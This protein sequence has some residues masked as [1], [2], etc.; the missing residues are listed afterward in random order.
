[1]PKACDDGFHAEA[2]AGGRLGLVLH[3]RTDPTPVA[4]KLISWARSHGNQVIADARDAAR[5]PHGVVRVSE[6]VLAAEADAL[7]SLG[8]DGTMLG[9]LRLAARRC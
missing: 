8:G 4:E 5:L 6:P 2:Q 7:V 3:P 1:L 9:A